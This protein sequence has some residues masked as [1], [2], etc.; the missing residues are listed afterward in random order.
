MTY[1]GYIRNGVAVFEPP[2]PVADGTRVQ[3]DVVSDT[4]DFWNGKSLDAL[5]SAQGLAR[6]SSS[7]VLPFG[8]ADGDS[9]DE[10]LGLVREARR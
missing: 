6:H 1:S 5:A 3:I 4:S 9:V 7:T 8:W 10:F 2:V